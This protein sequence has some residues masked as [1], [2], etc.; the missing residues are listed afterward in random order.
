M[1]SFTAIWVLIGLAFLCTSVDAQTP[2][3]ALTGEQVV[4]R[5][6]PSVA[7]ILVGNDAGELASVGSAVIVRPEGVLLTAYHGVKQARGVQVRL[8]SGEIYDQVQLIGADERR[9]IAALRIPAT[10]LPAATAVASAGLKPGAA[11]FVVSNGAALPW[12]ASSGVFSSFRLAD[13]VSGAGSGYR[14]L[15][16][17]AHISPGSSGGVLVDTQGRAV[18]II[19][20]TLDRAQNVNFAVPL[21]AVL[22][23]AA[24]P[25]GTAFAS[26]G[27][28]KLPVPQSTAQT[29]EIQQPLQVAAEAPTQGPVNRLQAPDTANSQP[30]ESRDALAILRN[31]RTVYVDSE[32]MWLKASVMKSAI[33]KKKKFVAWG[34]S[35]VDQRDLADVVLRIHLIGGTE[36]YTYELQHLNTS[37][38]LDSG[39]VTAFHPVLWMSGNT[40]APM[41][42]D[43]LI[44][45]IRATGRASGSAEPTKSVVKTERN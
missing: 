24:L 2:T 18:G 7:L 12:T 42:A 26:G 43:A 32:T 5:V 6:A 21:D 38:T 29:N 45:T 3:P 36:D 13:E 8:K 33:Y 10:N 23:L 31:F 37:I 16:F 40:A 34:I 14:L 35:V 41:I 4:D 19:V 9:D 39:K 44:K 30:L 1:K 25:G 20:A 27:S 11:M 22:G 15:Q 17:T 28:L